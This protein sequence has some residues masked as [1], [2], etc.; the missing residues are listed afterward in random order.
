MATR[1]HKEIKMTYKIQID[2]VIR[3]ATPEEI[4][5][6]E[7]REVAAAE[8]QAQAEAKAQAKAALLER[9]GITAEDAALL[10]S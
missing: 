6:I 9:L 8:V 1:T 4:A 10:L 7:A 2:D 3:D 5:E